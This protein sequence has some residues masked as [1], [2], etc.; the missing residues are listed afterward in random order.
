MPGLDHVNLQ[1]TRLAETVSFYRDVIGLEQRDPPGLD[2]TLVQWM[3]D[4][5]GH[6]IVHISTVGSLLGEAPAE[7]DGTGTGAVHHIALDCTGHDGM[8][9]KL[10]A[11]GL[12]FRLNHVAGIDLRQI[13]VQ[14]P[15][16][17]L[18]ELNYRAGQH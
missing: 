12:S 13:F 4:E 16:G 3:H 5:R 11:R 6:G 7:L 9:A 17:V 8:V 15:N 10:Q 1:T 18:L 14:D 2:P